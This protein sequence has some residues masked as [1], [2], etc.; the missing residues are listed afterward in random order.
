MRSG[1][2]FA[3]IA[4]GKLTALD[5]YTASLLA[6]GVQDTDTLTG[7]RGLR[8][9]HIVDK[10][11]LEASIDS[12]MTSPVFHDRNFQRLARC[13]KLSAEVLGI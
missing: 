5:A 4:T 7:M 11:K 6:T 3:S 1:R 13:D 12:E 2:S 10:S 9:L 8:G